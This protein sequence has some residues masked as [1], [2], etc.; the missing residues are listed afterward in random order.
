MCELYDSSR[1]TM[2]Q[3]GRV[4]KIHVSYRFNRCLSAASNAVEI[5]MAA[6]RARDLSFLYFS[7]IWKPSTSDNTT[8]RTCST[9]QGK[10]ELQSAY[11]IRRFYGYMK[12]VDLHIQAVTANMALGWMGPNRRV[13]HHTHMSGSPCTLGIVRRDLLG[14]GLCQGATSHQDFISFF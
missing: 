3:V 9:I 4:E 13:P 8:S 1:M 7:Y 14:G 5:S 12:A 10:A 6:N 2:C 11:I